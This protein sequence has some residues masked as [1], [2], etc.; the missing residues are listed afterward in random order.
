MNHLQIITQDM[1]GAG[2]GAHSLCLRMSSTTRVPLRL[3]P[4]AN[5]PPR[6]TVFETIYGMNNVSLVRLIDIKSGYIALCQSEKDVDKI[7]TKEATA[8]LDKIGIIPKP[9]PEITSKRSVICRRLD[10]WVGE[11]QAEEIKQEINRNHEYARVVEVIKFGQHTHVCKITFETTEMAIKAEQNGLLLFHVAITPDQIER[12]EYI[13]V[14]MCFCCYKLEDHTTKECPDLGNKICSEC[15]QP[16]HIFNECSSTTKKC[17]NCEGPHRTMSMACPEKKRI[18]KEK[19]ESRTIEKELKQTAT[20]A[21]VA[22]QTRK[23]DNKQRPI[24]Q[25]DKEIPT[26]ILTC[27]YYAHVANSGNPGSF[28]RELNQMLTNNGHKEMWFP[29]N[30]PSDTILGLSWKQDLDTIQTTELTKTTRDAN[31]ENKQQRRKKQKKTTKQNV[32]DRD[33]SYY[34]LDHSKTEQERRFTKGAE[35]AMETE[36]Y[37]DLESVTSRSNMGSATDLTVRNLIS[38]IEER[39]TAKKK[40]KEEE[41]KKIIEAKDLNLSIYTTAK[42]PFPKNNLKDLLAGIREG[43]HKYEYDAEYEETE[44]EQAL[45]SGKI[46]IRTE[47]CN[48]L[49]HDIYNK[50]R[51]GKIRSP[52]SEK[53][54]TQKYDR[55]PS[56]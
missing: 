53:I 19:K 34:R 32:Q 55:K 10:P 2:A 1:S 21:K 56:K 29:A 22:Q 37:S 15:S 52:Q 46:K 11:H 12:E 20:Y 13:N 33:D 26:E 50:K 27:I 7:L 25:L 16:G 3:K 4:G 23:E 24:L 38:E 14:Q 30:P 28:Q 18:I 5:K 6:G 35:G 31:E 41:E 47:Q 49:P 48:T 42:N 45:Y 51:S 44:I 9:P 54:R 43:R 8:V 39:K 17:I 36:S 40:Q